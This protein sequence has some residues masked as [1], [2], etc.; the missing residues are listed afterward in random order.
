[1]IEYEGADDNKPEPPLFAATM[2]DRLRAYLRSIG[3]RGVDQIPDEN[4]DMVVSDERRK[5]TEHIENIKE[6][7]G[8]IDTGYVTAEEAYNLSRFEL[9]N[10]AYKVRLYESCQKE[11]FR[12]QSPEPAPEA[13]AHSALAPIPGLTRGEVLSLIAELVT[14]I[15]AQQAQINELTE[16]R[17]ADQDIKLAS[18]GKQEVIEQ[19]SNASR[20]FEGV[21]VT[22]EIADE[23]SASSDKS[24][25]GTEKIN[26]TNRRKGNVAA[27]IRGLASTIAGL[28]LR[29]V[30]DT[31]DMSSVARH[32][33]TQSKADVRSKTHAKVR[34]K[35]AKV[36][37]GGD[38]PRHQLRN[39]EPTET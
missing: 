30:V 3:Y 35:I 6:L 31:E 17:A 11:L 32:L 39:G 5:R 27:H 4:L 2:N 7:P 1:M 18:F 19:L 24:A 34:I 28:N 13:A 38:S 21:D 15:A 23:A 16:Q 14:V 29:G 37:G 9:R 10:L 26:S 36:S 33:K 25:V 12:L 8:W 20:N 22:M